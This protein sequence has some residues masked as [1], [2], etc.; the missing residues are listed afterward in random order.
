MEETLDAAKG[1]FCIDPSAARTQF[2][3]GRHR[4]AG[5]RKF[6]V[7]PQ[8]QDAT[9]VADEDLDPLGVGI[10]IDADD[11]VKHVAVYFD[12]RRRCITVLATCMTGENVVKPLWTRMHVTHGEEGIILLD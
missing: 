5:D 11:I 8:V 3:R 6:F 4:D 2:E 7:R 10:P 9:F 1:R 12:D